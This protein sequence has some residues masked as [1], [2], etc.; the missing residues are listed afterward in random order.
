MVQP[1]GVPVVRLV[2]KANRVRLALSDA[3]IVT[4]VDAAGKQR[5]V[6]GVLEDGKA[7]LSVLDQS[8]KLL[9]KA[10]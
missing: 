5:G 2:D 10:P 9:W 4:L 7:F 3:P 6:V 8:G 1:S